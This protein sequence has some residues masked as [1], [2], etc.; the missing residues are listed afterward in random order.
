MNQT[1]WHVEKSTGHEIGYRAI[2]DD[3]GFTICNPSPM[4]AQNAALI[5]ASPELLDALY[6]AL[7]FVE[8]H[9]D[10]EIYKPNAVKSALK[11]IRAAIQKAVEQGENHA[12]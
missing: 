1:N 10:S 4:G 3:M 5:S 9:E 7:P 11:I 8:D 6:L 2:V 12:Y